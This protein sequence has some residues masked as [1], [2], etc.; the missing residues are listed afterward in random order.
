MIEA[1]LQLC[2]PVILAAIAYFWI[3]RLNDVDRFKGKIRLFFIL[4]FIAH[5]ILLI[6]NGES[7]FCGA[8]SIKSKAAVFL[9][10]GI[11]YSLVIFPAIFS[12]NTFNSLR[13]KSIEFVISFLGVFL[14]LIGLMELLASH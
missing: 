10:P 2:L 3:Y 8:C 7:W 12:D 11:G 4:I 14:F 5:F 1:L 6:N 13:E 9:F